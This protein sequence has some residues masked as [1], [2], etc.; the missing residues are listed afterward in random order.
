VRLG[1][2]VALRLGRLTT[3][4]AQ[5]AGDMFEAAMRDP[6]TKAFNRRYFSSRLKAE[7]AYATRHGA[8]LSLVAFDVD[9]FG[10]L[11]RA[12]GRSVGDAV[13]AHVVTVLTPS[14]RLEDVLARTVGDDFVLLLRGVRVE[15]AK[16]VAE[17]A[18]E[19]I[20]RAAPPHDVPLGAVTISAGIASS[21]EVG[22]LSAGHL[23]A[24]AE[25]RLYRARETGGNRIVGAGG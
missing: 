13:L 23:L 10:N 7:L 4:E 9:G 22:D 17:R 18:R 2:A 25:R 5:L 15:H 12:Y 3:A 14:L 11:N 6:L 21:D 19:T 20:E 8:T 24:I 1:S 16:A